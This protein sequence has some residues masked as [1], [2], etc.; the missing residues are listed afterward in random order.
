MNGSMSVRTLRR[1]EEKKVLMSAAQLG[2]TCSRHELVTANNYRCQCSS[3][4]CECEELFPSKRTG[5]PR[6]V[7]VTIVL[8]TKALSREWREACCSA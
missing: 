4:R 1:A 3:Y 2:D 5:M 8:P 7:G 6:G